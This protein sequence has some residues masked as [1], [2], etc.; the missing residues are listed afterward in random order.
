MKQTYAAIFDGKVEDVTANDGSWTP[1]NRN[2]VPYTECP[3]W[4]KTGDTFADG[5]WFRDGVEIVEPEYEIPTGPLLE[6]IT[7][8]EFDTMLAFVFPEKTAQQRN[9]LQMLL[10]VCG[11]EKLKSQ[12]PRV[13]GA[14]QVFSA[15]LG[16]ARVKELLSKP[17]DQQP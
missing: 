17:E 10:R 7:N 14:H 13:K 16:E 15:L 2:G 11:Q 12:H 6:A 9:V 5:K 3:D 8:A 1:N 4:V